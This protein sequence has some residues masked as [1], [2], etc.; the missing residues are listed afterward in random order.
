MQAQGFLEAGPPIFSPR[1]KQWRM[2]MSAAGLSRDAALRLAIA[3]TEAQ[4]RY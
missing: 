4:L 3:T 2:V 1:F